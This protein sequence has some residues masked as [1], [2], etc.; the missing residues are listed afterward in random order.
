MI[1]HGVESPNW[2]DPQIVDTFLF[3]NFVDNNRHEIRAGEKNA[4]TIHRRIQ[5]RSSEA[6]NQ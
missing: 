4:P 1:L 2:N 6:S 3:V 5:T